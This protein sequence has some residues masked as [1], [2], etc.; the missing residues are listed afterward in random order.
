[1]PHPE[2]LVK[3]QRIVC[4]KRYL[5]DNNSPGKVF[6]SYYLKNVGTSFLFRCNFNPSCLP[7]KLFFIKNVLKL[8]LISMVIRIK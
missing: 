5:D 2:S 8:G 7:C 4:L 6:L 1:M 3:T